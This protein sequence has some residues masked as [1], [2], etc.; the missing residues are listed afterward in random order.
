MQSVSKFNRYIAFCGTRGVPANYGGFETAVDQISR[1]FI[2]AGYNC[3]IYC[4]LSSGYDAVPEHEGRELVYVKGSKHR[5]LDTFISSIQV[6]RDLWKHRREYRHIFWFNNA[7]FPGI[8]MTLF[9]G[10]PMSVNTDGLEWR[11]K[12]WS[13]PFKLYYIISSFIISR[14]CP[15]LI[16]DSHAIREYYRTRFMRKTEF[17]PY[18]V[19]PT[20]NVE[21]NRRINIMRQLNLESGRYFLQITRFEPDNLPLEIARAFANSELIDR[22]YKFVVVGY[23]EKTDYGEKIKALDGRSGVVVL[24]AVYDP[25]ILAVLRE[26]CFCYLHGNSVGGTNPALL[27]AMAFCPRVLAIDNIFSREVLDDT[28]LFF[29]PTNIVAGFLRAVKSADKQESMHSRIRNNYQ[30][31]AVAESYMRLAEGKSTDYKV[32]LLEQET[33]EKES[34]V[35]ENVY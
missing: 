27:E 28:G 26:N 32:D 24:D 17:I 30:W 34:L 31:R 6:A 4:R 29:E 23:K 1:H 15:I 14:L 33:V 12:K 10:V 8:L 16:S 9:T 20:I 5:K 3:R 21:N 11:R 22:E 2:S 13:W 18:G 25:K 19:P 7:N 35:E